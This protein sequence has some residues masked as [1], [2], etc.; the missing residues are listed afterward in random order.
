MCDDIGCRV[1]RSGPKYKNL[2]YLVTLIKGQI[3]Q[4]FG[5]AGHQI[6]LND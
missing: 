3:S 5:R 2:N 1:P 6:S 4:S